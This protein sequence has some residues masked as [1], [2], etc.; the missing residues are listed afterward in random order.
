[1]ESRRLNQQKRTYLAIVVPRRC[2]KTRMITMAGQSWLHLLDPDISTYTGS[3]KLEMA[4]EI[5]LPIKSVMDGSDSHSLWTTLYGNWATGARTWKTGKVVHAARRNT[6][7]RDPSLGT[8]GVETSIVGSH[9][10]AIFRDDPISYDRL[11]TD[12]DWF[13]AVNDQTTSL[14]PVLEAD[15]LFVDVGTRYGSADQFGT[16]F[17]SPEE[18]GDGVATIEGMATD[19]ITTHP[20]GQW[21]VY[22]LAGRKSDGTPAIPRVWSDEAMKHYKQRNPIRYAAQVMNDPS[23]SD[24][25]PITR[26]QLKQCIVP[27]KEVP[28]SAL[29]YAIPCDLALW[30]GRKRINKDETVY[31]V[32][33]YPKNGSGDVYYIE[34]DGSMYWRDEEFAARLVSLVQRYRRKGFRVRGISNDKAKA[35]LTG[36]WATN[37]RNKF[38]DANEP[39]PPHFEFN[40]GS[41][42]KILRIS[43]V[44]NFWTDGHVKVVA[45]SPGHE[46]LF[47]QMER[48]G[49]MQL[50]AE[51]GRKSRKKDDWLDPMT[52]AFEP[53]FYQPM[54]R[55]MVNQAPWEKDAV[56]LPIEGIDPDLFTN[57]NRDWSPREPIR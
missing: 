26:D 9:P 12:S 8:F 14:I 31:E 28:W 56:T 23:D 16:Q 46:R 19:A 37:L 18:G 38:A 20:N 52:D 2:G 1:M 57:Q 4:G 49:E 11:K 42:Q 51:S 6:A 10:D 40:R 34:G 5:V 30:D 43:A 36:I 7:R 13:E 27:I 29:D 55:P 22:F 41:T 53:C 17:A 3:E 35:G 39:M 15:G 44:V 54:R 32:W 45:D 33:G 21:H 47:A 24:F 50:V 48:I 25:N